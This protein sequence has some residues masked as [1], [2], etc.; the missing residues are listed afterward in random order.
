MS[1]PVLAES[2]GFLLLSEQGDQ[3]GL[4]GGGVEVGALADGLQ[5]GLR[6][7]LELGCVLST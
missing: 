5:G 3:C 7:A 6:A 1:P 2:L 4:S